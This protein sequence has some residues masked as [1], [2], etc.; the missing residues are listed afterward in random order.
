MKKTILLTT[1]S[2]CLVLSTGMYAAAQSLPSIPSLPAAPASTPAPQG[3][4]FDVPA[5]SGGEAAPTLSSNFGEMA[6]E[7]EEVVEEPYVDPNDPMTAKQRSLA[8]QVSPD[9]FFPGYDARGTGAENGYNPQ[10][11]N[12]LPPGFG[13]SNRVVGAAAGVGVEE[14]ESP[15]PGGPTKIEKAVPVLPPAGEQM[16]LERFD[17]FYG[18]LVGG[19]DQ[20]LG[21]L[22]ADG[23]DAGK[24]LPNASVDAYAS[25]VDQMSAAQ[26]NSFIDA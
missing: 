23:V 3:N 10:D 4:F 13:M 19:I 15:I 9:L 8:N 11:P 7:E 18:G 26:R 6:L 22:G 20:R 25:E 12:A 16:S 2:V 21:E 1:T 14:E 5:V 17:E 24:A